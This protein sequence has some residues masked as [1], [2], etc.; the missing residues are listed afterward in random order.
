MLVT[1]ALCLGGILGASSAAFCCDCHPLD[2]SPAEHAAR[3][4]AVFVGTVSSVRDVPADP[5]HSPN[6]MWE[7]PVTEATFEV[8]DSLEANPSSPVLI[9]TPTEGGACGISFVVGRSYLVFAKREAGRLR[10]AACD[11]TAPLPEASDTLRQL[12]LSMP[13][14]HGRTVGEANQSSQL[15]RCA[16]S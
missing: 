6:R 16:R 9:L 15:T 5:V 3:Y 10:S 13:T 1:G 14:I 4:D 8:F 2:E 12:E 11:G 7:F